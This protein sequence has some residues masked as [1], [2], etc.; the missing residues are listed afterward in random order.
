MV[1]NSLIHDSNNQLEAFVAALQNQAGEE[2]QPQL[3]SAELYSPG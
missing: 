1:D 2:C 3:V